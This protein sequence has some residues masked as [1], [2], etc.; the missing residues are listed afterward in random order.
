MNCWIA[1]CNEGDAPS[2]I[3]TVELHVRASLRIA[4]AMSRQQ[5]DGSQACLRI[6]AGQ[7]R[8]HSSC[9]DLS[10]HI[11]ALGLDRAVRG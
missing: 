2:T 9:L 10:P 8:V 1:L 7:K 3:H 6:A 4:L 5:L 11:A